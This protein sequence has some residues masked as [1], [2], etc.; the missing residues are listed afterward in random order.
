MYMYE[1]YQVAGFPIRYLLYT[2]ALNKA[3]VHYPGFAT[4]R[5]K[6]CVG[7]TYDKKTAEKYTIINEIQ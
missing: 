4:E 1:Y 3:L 2:D 7:V 6:K 5:I